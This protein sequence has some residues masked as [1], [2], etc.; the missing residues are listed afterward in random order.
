ME[1]RVLSV[2]MSLKDNTMP[3]EGYCVKS[4]IPTFD[5]IG[6]DFDNIGAVL[7]NLMTLS[8]YTGFEDKRYL[9]PLKDE[10]ELEVI[11]QFLYEYRK[12]KE[13]ALNAL[14]KVKEAIER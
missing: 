2:K 13:E 6:E 12:S 3:G 5:S 4:D 8:G 7:M 11:E 14:N 10:D 1:S 9:I